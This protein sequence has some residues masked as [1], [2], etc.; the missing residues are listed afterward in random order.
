[1]AK[2]PCPIEARVK[3]AHRDRCYQVALPGGTV[4]RIHAP[5]PPSPST[6]QAFGLVAKAAKH[7]LRREVRKREQWLELEP[8]LG[9]EG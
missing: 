7:W 8:E 4:A 2:T 9:G 6:L 5:R 3:R 1:M